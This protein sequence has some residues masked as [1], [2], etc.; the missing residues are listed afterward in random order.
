M[1]SVLPPRE[2]VANSQPAKLL[3]AVPPALLQLEVELLFDCKLFEQ[4]DFDCYLAVAGRMPNMLREISRVRELTFREVGEGTGL[5]CDTD[6]YDAYYRHLFLW[7][8]V[9]R[10]LVGAYRVG[11]GGEIMKAHGRKG[12]Y[13]NTLFS[14]N[15]ELDPVLEQSIELGR[16]F[17][18][19]TYQRHRLPLFMLWQGILS[20]LISNPGYRYVLGPVSISN[21]YQELSKQLMVE[22]VRRYYFNHELAKLVTAKHPYIVEEDNP[23][24]Q[25]LLNAS[26][27]DV[28]KLDR[29]IA[30]IEPSSYCVPV[31]LKKYLQQNARIIGFNRDPQF[32]DALDGLMIL[33]LNDI[34]EKTIHNLQKG[35]EKSAEK[36]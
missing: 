8:R 18:R 1:K 6:E 3:S 20:V 30:E 19:K 17:I 15:K 27:D 32:S 14:M 13:T 25:M 9:N 11:M 24:H 22:F 21:Q 12:F 16:S 35:L 10:Q 31:L 4:G 33:D 7:D 23:D 5:C 29:I 34:P 26:Q 28:R 36:G 2:Q